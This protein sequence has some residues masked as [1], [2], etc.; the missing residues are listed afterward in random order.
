M[1]P[2][3]SNWAGDQPNHRLPSKAYEGTSVHIQATAEE[4]ALRG[5]YYRRESWEQLEPD[6]RRCAHCGE[7]RF[8]ALPLTQDER[9]IRHDLSTQPLLGEPTQP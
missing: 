3:G 7:V 5:W 1:S 6:T 9:D 4:A 2:V 8:D